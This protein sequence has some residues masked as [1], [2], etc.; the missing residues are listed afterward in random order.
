MV[1]VDPPDRLS[2][3]AEVNRQGFGGIIQ[4]VMMY[5]INKNFPTDYILALRVIWAPVGLIFF[6][7]FFIPESPWFHVK[8]G[9]TEAAMK[10]LKQLY[11]NVDGYDFAEELAIIENTIVHEVNTVENAPSFKQVFRGN[12]LVRLRPPS[13]K[14]A[15]TKCRSE[16]W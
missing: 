14:Q 8:R 16:P 4:S 12:N 11:S 13:A 7:F 9:N 5:Q 3:L 10:S 1:R 2:T 15:L 6:C